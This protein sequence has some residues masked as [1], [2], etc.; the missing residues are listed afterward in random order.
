MDFPNFLHIGSS[1]V[2]D[3]NHG[4]PRTVVYFKTRR[5]IP[6]QV[7]PWFSLKSLRV[8]NSPKIHSVG[9]VSLFSLVELTVDFLKNTNT[10]K[11]GVFTLLLRSLV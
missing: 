1:L 8:L 11:D 2:A 7:D 10:N 4:F 6:N 5:S 3:V 9:T